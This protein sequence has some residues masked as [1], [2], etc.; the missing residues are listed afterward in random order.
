MNDTAMLN[1]VIAL[2]LWTQGV[3]GLLPL[4]RFRAYF[5]REVEIDD[6]KF[7]E[8]ARVPASVSLPNRN[9]M[10]LLEVPLL[11]YVVCLCFYV[12]HLGEPLVLV[13]AWTYVGL[14][15]LH[16]VVHLSYNKV[17]HR[18]SVFAL[19]NFV[20]LAL[21]LRLWWRVSA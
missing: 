2:A 6:F 19:S 16:S 5:R 17:M 1:P 9:Y 13:G 12:T 20:L 21:W 11:F 3:L 18:L 14:R 15:A 7:G 10:N 8:S 4:R